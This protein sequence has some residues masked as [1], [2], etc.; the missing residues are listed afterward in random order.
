MCCSSAGDRNSPTQILFVK[1]FI[2]HFKNTFLKMLFV[3]I[4]ISLSRQ[5][6]IYLFGDKDYQWVIIVVLWTKQLA[7]DKEIPVRIRSD[8]MKCWNMT[9]LNKNWHFYLNFESW[10]F[11]LQDRFHLLRKKNSGVC[12][13]FIAACLIATQW[14]ENDN[15][16]LWILGLLQ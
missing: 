3:S 4:K 15:G 6:Q 1:Y 11:F 9:N 10:I 8:V 5:L 13:S 2:S 16:K 12:L 14:T 7:E